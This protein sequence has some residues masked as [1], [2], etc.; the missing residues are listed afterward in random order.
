MLE[1]EEQLT[2]A[3]LLDHVNPFVILKGM[4]C[5]R[6]ELGACDVRIALQCCVLTQA[7]NLSFLQQE[8]YQGEWVSCT[9]RPASETPIP[10]FALIFVSVVSQNIFYH[11]YSRCSSVFTTSWKFDTEQDRFSLTLL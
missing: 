1:V 11:K 6:G 7:C 4:L 10:C 2:S 3:Q 5:V 8:L 9:K